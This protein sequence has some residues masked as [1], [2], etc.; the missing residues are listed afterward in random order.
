MNRV[1]N[2]IDTFSFEYVK[3]TSNLY[4]PKDRIYRGKKIK[5]ITFYSDS[6]NAVDYVGFPLLPAAFFDSVFLDLYDEDK[7][8]IMRDFSAANMLCGVNIKTDIDAILNYDIS[9]IRILS[10][11]S[12]IGNNV[13]SVLCSIEYEEKV[14]SVEEPTNC[15]TINIPVTG[16]NY[17]L[18]R[19]LNIDSLA[20]F[21]IKR[22]ILR[23]KTDCYLTLRNKNGNLF[24]QI[25]GSYLTQ[26]R[27]TED[28]MLPNIKL[29]INNC[30][31][32]K[33]NVENG[34]LTI[35]FYY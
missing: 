22:I 21:S 4:I 35:E 14:I 17:I 15:Y 5:R 6:D 30:Y 31:I 8:V 18:F 10:D 28:I 2:N 24:N 9:G 11:T 32:E 19:D 3:G 1:I 7:N 12:A 23:G 20:E 16:K 33:P 27:Y 25:S 13:Y 26:N 34:I 29:D